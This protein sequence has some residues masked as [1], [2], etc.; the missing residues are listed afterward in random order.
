MAKKKSKKSS[1]KV[2]RKK[3]RPK[4]RI[5]SGLATLAL[6]LNVIFPGIGSLIG[7]KI[8]TGIFQLILIIA[9]LFF[10]PLQIGLLVWVGAVIWGIVTGVKLMQEAQ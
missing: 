6:I 9:V 7:G 2:S 3:A 8:K 4:K 1:S 5:T 10:F